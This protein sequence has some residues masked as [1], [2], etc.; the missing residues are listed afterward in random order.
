[1]LT[2]GASAG[3]FLA[4]SVLADKNCI[5]FVESP[6]YFIL[7]H[8]LQD[9]GIGPDRLVPIPMTPDGL[10]VNYLEVQLKKRRQ[11]F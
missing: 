1:M 2:S 7:L 5:A 4:L 9:L 10:D 3:V 11:L 8:M 6:T